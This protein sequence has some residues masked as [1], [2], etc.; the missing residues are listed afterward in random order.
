M[1]QSNYIES[2][3]GNRGARRY[4][5]TMLIDIYHVR[6]LVLLG[7]SVGFILGVFF[8]LATYLLAGPTV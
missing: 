3:A 8:T 4:T 5:D 7:V 6:L 1:K 2:V